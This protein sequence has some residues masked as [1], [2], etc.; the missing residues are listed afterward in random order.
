MEG[1]RRKEEEENVVADKSKRKVLAYLLRLR[2]RSK[3]QTSRFSLSKKKTTSILI[4][5]QSTS[6]LVS[7]SPISSTPL[8]FFSKRRWKITE[9]NKTG[10]LSAQN[11][12]AVTEP[13][14]ILIYSNKK[15]DIKFKKKEENLMNVTL[16]LRWKKHP[17]RIRN[18]VYSLYSS[19][20]GGCYLSSR[21][22]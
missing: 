17:P 19:Q 4:S 16:L 10:T 2:Q 20:E 8:C 9:N 6:Q 12:S 13:L 14:F 3:E 22:A 5:N 1:I 21:R 18:P 7:F 15:N 11:K